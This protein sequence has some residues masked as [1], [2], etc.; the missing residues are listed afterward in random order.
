M[1]RGCRKGFLT[2]ETL[3]QRLE[4]VLPEAQLDAASTSARVLLGHAK[5]YNVVN[6]FELAETTE[7]E[8]TTMAC[9]LF[10]H[11][12]SPLHRDAIE[13]YVVAASQLYSRGTVIANLM[14]IR[15]A[16]SINDEARASTAPRPRFD[17]AVGR[18]PIG[19][20]ADFTLGGADVRN[21]TLKQVFLPERWP[22]TVP[23][24]AEMQSVMDAYGLLIPRLPDWDDVMKPTGWDNAINRM[25][26]KFLGNLKVHAKKNLLKAVIGYLGV[27]A[28]HDD[29][30]RT[31]IVDVVKGRLRPLAVHDDDMAMVLL[32]RQVLGV[33]EDDMSWHTPKE[34]K[35]FSRD[36][37]LL[38]FFLV[39]HGVQG[40]SYLPV[41]TRGRKYCYM[42]TKIVTALFA[43]AGRRER[44]T[45][46]V[47]GKR[48]RSTSRASTAG[49]AEAPSAAGI[50]EAPPVAGIA[51]A[52]SAAGDAPTQGDYHTVSLGEFLGITQRRFNDKRN[53]LRSRLQR[54]YRK[55]ARAETP[56]KKK[57]I[58][59]RLAR[60]W[61]MNGHG[62][63]QKGARIDSAE[64]DGVGLRLCVKCPIDLRPF[65]VAIPPPSNEDACGGA[66]AAPSSGKP[67]RKKA[68][69]KKVLPATSGFVPVDPNVEHVKPVFVALDAGRAKLFSAAISRCACKKPSSM[70]FKRHRYYYEM[71]HHRNRRWELERMA[72]VPLVQAALASLASSGGVGNC[73]DEKWRAYL[74]ASRENDNI[75]HA[76]F[77]LDKE[78]ALWRMRMFR[79]KRRSLDLAVQRLLHA[80]LVRERIERPLVFAVG[81]AGFPSTGQ[82]ELPAP[83]SAIMVAFRRA[84]QR[85]SRSGRTVVI[86]SL[87][88]FRTTMCCCACGEVTTRPLVAVH[89]QNG[90]VVLRKSGR[91]RACTSCETT[92][93]IRD[94]DVQAARNILWLA[95]AMYYGQ[96]RPA[97]L[98]CGS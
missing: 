18:G 14:A 80:A 7:R 2:K 17:V 67:H 29:A 65:I 34:T 68:Q 61:G 71:G 38:H 11:V 5:F 32:L 20:L 84:L 83:T 25:A 58:F 66:A 30:S 50:A 77:V 64:T 33:R 6:D 43:E 98:R 54:E 73:D 55:K 56:G 52:P 42:D 8:E 60:R 39:R 79:W 90:E 63:L 91:L 44:R 24:N 95:Q 53:A 49:I 28:L 86:L 16:G 69:K 13:K 93:K 31:A 21:S 92:V 89:G 12:E 75:L 74:N 46:K 48:R 59:R 72:S 36:V 19:D 85:V 27:A 45:E 47:C 37:L 94:R 9:Y 70:A 62:H 97:Y 82:G 88:E 22:T 23:R 81:D 51:E 1:T 35:V 78:R 40:R 15:R 76:E 4:A 57:K 41:A 96:D 87:N 26:T 10:T 3:I